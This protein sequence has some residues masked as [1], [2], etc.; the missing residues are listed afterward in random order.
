[1]L[2]AR[3]EWRRWPGGCAW[4]PG[5]LLAGSLVCRAGSYFDQQR[6]SLRDRGCR[7]GW[8]VDRVLAGE[9]RAGFAFA[10]GVAAQ[11]LI[12]DAEHVLHGWLAAALLAGLRL[13]ELAARG[14]WRD[15]LARGALCAGGLLAGAGLAAFQ[16]LP[17]VE[18]VAQSAR[19]TGSFDVRNA[20]AQGVYTP[21]SFLFQAAQSSRWVAVGVLPLVAALLALGRGRGALPW[22]LGAG[23]AL[24]VAQLSFG[25]ALFR[26]YHELPFADLFRRPTFLDL[27][28]SV[29][30]CWRGSRSRACPIGRAR[31]GAGSGRIR[32]GWP[33]W[34]APRCC[35]SSCTDRT[36]GTPSSWRCCSRWRSTARWA[37][38]RCGARRCCSSRASS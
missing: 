29:R 15:A 35:S 4:W 31:R 17:T 19:A 16:L 11:L 21:G 7:G 2:L 28:V 34:R 38:A 27:Y 9:R 1:M 13:G 24:A 30:R 23:T 5:A 14:G 12:G 6:A 10:V 18:L 26:A 20:I 36:A 33:R 37:R 25:G 8:L 3:A 22:L 32:A